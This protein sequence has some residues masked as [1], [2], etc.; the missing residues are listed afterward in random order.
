MKMHP[1]IYY[2]QNINDT[3]KIETHVKEN[4]CKLQAIPLFNL[5]LLNTQLDHLPKNKKK[6]STR[7]QMLGNFFDKIVYQK[8]K[9]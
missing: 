2:G 1:N 8:K 3:L 9:K 5:Q 6:D 4:V 7:P